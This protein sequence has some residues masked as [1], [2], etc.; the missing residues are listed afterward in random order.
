[1][2]RR[3]LIA[4]MGA[5]A[6]LGVVA[7]A[8]L[9]RAPSGVDRSQATP[10]EALRPSGVGGEE[11]A[12]RHC[13]RCHAVPAPEELPKEA[14]PFVMT[15]MG[16]YFGHRKNDGPFKRIALEAFI[17]DKPT[18]HGED[19]AAIERYYVEAAP[20]Q[21]QMRIER[22]RLPVS[23]RFRGVIPPMDIPKND[24][25]TLVRL[26]PSKPRLYVGSG[27]TLSLS[28]YDTTTGQRVGQDHFATE[29]V[30]LEFYEG[31]MRLSVMGSFDHDTG[32]GA[33]VDIEGF[34]QGQARRD[35]VL[36]SS[37]HRLTRSITADVNGDKRADLLVIGFGD[38]YAG[39]G[40]GRL[41]MLWATESFDL[42]RDK[43]PAK[44]PPGPLPGAWRETVLSDQAG[45]LDGAIE[46]LDKDGRPDV[47]IVTAQA[48][49]EVVA[50]MNKGGERFERV[51]IMSRA[52]GWG[53]NAMAM[54][55]FD[56]DGHKDLVVVNGNN[57][58]I[59]NPPLKPYHG[60]RI[61]QN[62]GDL[63][64]TERMFFPFYGAIKA[65][66]ADFDGDG[67]LDIAAIS[68]FPDWE[69][70][71]QPETFAFLENKGGWTFDPSGAP[72]GVWGRWLTMDLGDVDYD[73][74]PDVILGLGSLANGVPD[75][76]FEAYKARFQVL[77]SVVFLKNKGG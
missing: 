46:D 4:L 8:I 50:W 34:E 6:G 49:Q 30:G 33:V 75:A 76:L 28:A 63:T 37:Y 51:V 66:P 29:P 31:G 73:G 57:M 32:T 43:A 42:L 56:G 14:W 58:E 16:N 65:T 24:L 27:H 13:G 41:S 71:P 64:F 61:Y 45:A 19:L 11:L 18:V 60:V 55:D 25:V 23:A 9:D 70:E 10:E 21:A 47:V 2:N 77:P 52:P 35:R 48:R 22:P 69:D 5:L 36:L 20:A 59:H 72:E 17:P 53:H 74:A 26:H 44:L 40:F 39:V 7:W 12:R 15:W 38:G 3:H 54:A 1:M 62:N 67:D 68:F